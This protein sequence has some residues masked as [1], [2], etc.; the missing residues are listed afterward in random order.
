MFHWFTFLSGFLHGQLSTNQFFSG[1]ALAGLIAAIGRIAWGWFNK[2]YYLVKR[3]CIVSVS[4]HSNDEMYRPLT[5]W[6]QDK[7]FDKF[8]REYRMRTRTDGHSSR[9]EE[10]DGTA[11]I[12]LTP[13]YG[14]YYFRWKNRMMRMDVKKEEGN[15]GAAS[16][17][18]SFAQTREFISIAYYGFSRKLLN[19]MLAEVQDILKK[20]KE[21]GV[22]L[23]ALEYNEW[24]HQAYLKPPSRGLVLDDGVLESIHADIE[25]F[26]RRREWYYN[27]GIPWRR[28]Y[29]LYGPPG[30]GKTS[31]V[32]HLALHFNLPLHVM[33]AEGYAK[34]GRAIHQIE[35]KAI[36]LCED[37]DCFLASR[38]KKND[39]DTI[40]DKVQEATAL[41]VGGSGSQLNAAIGSFLN[42][43]DGIY[44]AEGI[45]VIMT[46]NF[47]H[48]LD[49]ALSRP[50]RID[51]KIHLDNCTMNHALIMV[52]K[53]FP[54]A[55]LDRL[56]RV[57]VDKTLSPAEIQEACLLSHDESDVYREIRVAVAK[58]RT[59]SLQLAG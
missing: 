59:H 44:G 39:D 42:G 1:A 53:F 19:Q 43:L 12:Y 26:Y 34:M 30:T 10:A 35:G 31:L 50:G 16:H 51:Q 33:T 14:T 8:A 54:T 28:G 55:R 24:R 15:N 29:L 3:C 25:K 49:P 58:K 11:K 38:V 20:E 47:A 9:D 45:L 4:I 6:L 17:V 21:T 41:A 40:E 46:T 27:L 23:Y 37:V 13:D 52:Q 56:N 7:K 32:R 2:L 48:T 57:Y 22:S 5:K 18:S 36:L